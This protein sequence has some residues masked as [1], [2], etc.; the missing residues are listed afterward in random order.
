MRKWGSIITLF[1]GL[2]LVVLL[3]PA[4]VLLL[5]DFS[6][7]T[8][9]YEH[10][11]E[12]YAGWGTWIT[13]G[14]LVCSEALLLFLRVDTSFKRLRRRAHIL[15]SSIFT[16]FFLA[17]LT[18]AGAY[19]LAVAPK[20]D[21]GIDLLNRFLQGGGAIAGA[22]LVFWW[23]WGIL[24]YLFSRNSGDVVTRAVSWMLRGSVLELLI[25]VPAHVLVRRRHE[26]SAPILT[27]FGITTG[28]AIML[29][30]FGPSVLLLYKKRME[31]YSK[32]ASLAPSQTNPVSR[33][34]H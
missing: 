15:V 12:G 3:L 21:T 1:Y 32:R 5:G 2:I 4:F 18:F 6:G 8:G 34:T 25:A 13:I 10:V 19:S 26:C 20:G 16:A 17:L 11:K 27:S 28:I 30:S 23:F 9:F 31:Q 22:C 24:F 14:V 33:E 7:W 29:M